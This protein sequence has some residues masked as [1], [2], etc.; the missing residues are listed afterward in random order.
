MFLDKCGFVTNI[1]PTKL[2][3]NNNPCF[4]TSMQKEDRTHQI[5]VTVNSTIKQTLLLEK[6]ESKTSLMLTGLGS[7]KKSQ[8]KVLFY[9]SN[10]RSQMS[11]SSASFT[12]E[13]P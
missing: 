3:S 9:N 12:H 6:L 2:S 13:N 4:N 10:T 5:K 7:P 11:D 8:S 1:T